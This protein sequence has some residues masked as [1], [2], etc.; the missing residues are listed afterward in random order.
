MSV[1]VLAAPDAFSRPASAFR[2]TLTEEER[3]NTRALAEELTRTP[4]GLLDDREWLVQARRLS[5]RLPV[6]LVE[7]MREFRND[8]GR[9]G[10]LSLARLPIAEGALPDTPSARDSVERAAALPASVA[11]LI[12]HQLGE[13]VAYRAEKQGALVQNIVPVR[14]LA[15][16]QSNAGSVPLKLHSEN[17]FHPHR[18]D[19]IGLMCL[20]NDHEGRA[21]TLVSSVRKALPLLGEADVAVLR[22]ARFVTEAPPSFRSGESTDPHPVLGG[23]A[24]DA[25]IRV[26]F[27][28]TTALDGEAGQALERLHAA[29]MRVSSSLV[30][31][32]G[33]MVFAD[34]RLVVH[35]RTDFTPRYDGRDR[36]LHRIYVHLDNRRSLSHRVGA[37]PVLI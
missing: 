10:V 29:L 19:Y 25:N 28:A 30:L 3:S 5:C 1:S 23:I 12:G 32:P 9:N 37:G 4:P 24:Q 31:G 15:G 21:G 36:W 26:D 17:A 34:N 20:R 7:A 2:L 22:R 11:M 14:G 16:S 13:V 6:R 8:A 35:G 27:N 18:P 33:E